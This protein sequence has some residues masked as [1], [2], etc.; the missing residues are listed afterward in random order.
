MRLIVIDNYDSFTYNL[1][2][3]FRELGLKNDMKIVR[4]DQFEIDEVEVYKNILLSP[5]SGLPKDAGHMP[6]VIRR[7]APE[8]NI[9]GVCLGHQ[10]IG[11]NF[12]CELY[13]PLKVY[14]GLVT[15][16]RIISRDEIFDGIP[17]EFD[18]C[19]Y[20]SWVINAS[21]VSD[22]LEVTSIDESGSVMSVRHK[23]L[24]VRGV[25]FH[26]ESVMTQHGKKIIQ[27]WIE[28]E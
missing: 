20:H 5:G 1:V 22:D 19:R 23:L 8:K 18:V 6:E 2:H 9:L 27:N 12:G 16:V 15:P 28:L 10:G 25:Q 24:N 26:P 4:N 7:F 17:E 3:I 21:S 14:H 11:E 13:N